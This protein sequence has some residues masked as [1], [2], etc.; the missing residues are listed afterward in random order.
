MH[1]GHGLLGGY[2]SAGLV[3]DDDA[4]CTVDEVAGQQVAALPSE[5]VEL[6]VKGHVVLVTGDGGVGCRGRE[7]D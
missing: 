1:D 4:E 7:R 2:P 5:L 6:L 3:V